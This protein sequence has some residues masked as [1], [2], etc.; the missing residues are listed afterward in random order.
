M[1]SEFKLWMKI[2]I[3]NWFYDLMAKSAR[4][5]HVAVGSVRWKRQD[6][7]QWLPRQRSKATAVLIRQ[8][9]QRYRMCRIKT[10]RGLMRLLTLL[11][12]CRVAMALPPLSSNN[13]RNTFFTVRSMKT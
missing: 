13:C 10:S 3:S 7:S 9:A 5:R 11:T 2:K 8:E 1:K 12:D 6:K 4:D